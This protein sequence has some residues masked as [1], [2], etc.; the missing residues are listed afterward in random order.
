MTNATDGANKDH[1][2][3][4][5]KKLISDCAGEMNDIDDERKG[6]NERAGEIRKKLK[7]SGVQIPAFEF[8][9]KLHN[10]DVDAR[11]EYLDSLR[12]NM[13]GMGLGGQGTLFID[14]GHSEAA[15]GV[16]QPEAEEDGPA[17]ESSHDVHDPENQTKH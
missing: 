15:H 11:D 6:L 13:E 2:V 16:N 1:N 7:D 17:E 14:E 9:R 10:M 4:D 5:L 12:I 3:G 8:A